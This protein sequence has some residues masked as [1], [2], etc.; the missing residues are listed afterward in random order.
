MDRRI[1][2]PDIEVR[3]GRPERLGIVTNRL[4][5]DACIA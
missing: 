2:V 3:I 4:F 5:D 1:S